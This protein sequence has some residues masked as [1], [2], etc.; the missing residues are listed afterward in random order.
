[1]PSIES[2][3]A[4][5]TSVRPVAFPIRSNRVPIQPTLELPKS[6]E[7]TEQQQNGGSSSSYIAN[8]T[9][10]GRTMKFKHLGGFPR[11]RVPLESTNAVNVKPKK[12]EPSPSTPSSTESKSAS[13]TEES[14]QSLKKNPFWKVAKKLKI[15]MT[16]PSN[17]GT[18]AIIDKYFKNVDLPENFVYIMSNE[19]KC[20]IDEENDYQCSCMISCLPNECVNYCSQIECSANCRCGELC[21]NRMF[22]RRAYPELICFGSKGKGI[23]VKS[24]QVLIKKGDFI[25]EYV[26]EVISVEKFENRASRTYQK[27]LHHYCMNLGERKIIDATWMGNIGRFI[28]HSCDPNACTETW[29]VDGRLRVGIF[30]IRDIKMGEEITYN[31]HFTIYDETEQQTCKCGAK[32][33]TGFIGKKQS[34]SSSGSEEETKTMPRVAKRSKKSSP[35]P[36]RKKIEKTSSPLSP[37]SSNDSDDFFL[38]YI[39]S[40]NSDSDLENV[41]TDSD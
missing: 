11:K 4:T 32:T 20:T 9:F 13:E 27:S 15:T 12:K 41:S 39:S 25:T 10:T 19:G 34:D 33:C 40:D 18:Q 21:Y 31:Y 37:L 30:A 29:L 6:T 3:A 17:L 38:N 5:T 23:G 14:A 28:N 7:K 1:M 8:I 24:N 36:K 16:D 2:S 35:S 26:G 22:A